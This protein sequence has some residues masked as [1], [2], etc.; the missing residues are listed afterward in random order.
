[1]NGGTALDEMKLPGAN[2]SKGGLRDPS[3]HRDGLLFSEAVFPVPPPVQ[4][5]LLRTQPAPRVD[6]EPVSYTHLSGS[7]V[8][9]VLIYGSGRRPQSYLASGTSKRR[10]TRLGGNDKLGFIFLSL[11][12]RGRWAGARF[13]RRVGRSVALRGAS[14]GRP[15]TKP[16]SNLLHPPAAGAPSDEQSPENRTAK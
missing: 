10:F 6:A 8:L 4:R 15:K 14:R 16:R 9:A 13:L 11:P 1:M 3:Q 12:R 2:P 7:A 5:R